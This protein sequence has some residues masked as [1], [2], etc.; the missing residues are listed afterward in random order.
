MLAGR[1]VLTLAVAGVAACLLVSLGFEA[2]DNGNTEPPTRLPDRASTPAPGT[3]LRELADTRGFYIGA[4]IQSGLLA[5]ESQYAETAAREFNMVVA[6]WEMKMDPIERRRGLLDFTGADAIIAFAEAHD[7]AVR[8]HA[9]VWHGATPDWVKVG[10]LTRDQAID[11]LRTYIYTVVG[12]YRGR[13]MAWDV[14]NEGIDDDGELRRTVWANLIGDDY[15]E[16]AFRWAHEA[17]PGALLF[18][19]DYGAEG[20]GRK[21]D[22]VYELVKGLVDGGVPIHGVGLQMHISAHD[23][24]SPGGAAEAARLAENMARL[25]ALGLQVHITEMDVRTPGAQ[26]TPE[27]LERQAQVYRGALETCLQAEACT[28]FL[29][30]GITD[31]YTWIRSFF[32]PEDA[33]PLIF[34]ENYQPKPAYFA[35]AAALAGL[36]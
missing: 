16:M 20:M 7:M 29:M 25:N 22:A 33:A 35:L 28:A 34:D 32:G 15:I 2:L 11:L 24:L 4:A 13:V 5:Q 1:I 3:T 8:G 6:E 10:D 26:R 14:V 12:R 9:L 19:N 36:D 18:Y 31:K 17:D 30:W 23:F 27:A 21:S